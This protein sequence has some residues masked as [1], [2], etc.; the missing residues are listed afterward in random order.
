MTTRKTFLGGIAGTLLLLLSGTVQ[1]TTLLGDSIEILSLFPTVADVNA[2]GT[3][4]VDDT[5]LDRVTF[6]GGSF[7]HA[8]ALQ[9]SF[10]S[11]FATRFA[12]GN[13]FNPD[14][15]NFISFED[16]DFADGSVISG[17][18]LSSTFG[19]IGVE[20][21]IFGDDFVRFDVAGLPTVAGDSIVVDL[22]TSGG[23][24]PVPLPAGL[25]LF[26]LAVGVLGFARRKSKQI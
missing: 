19:G 20:D 6:G 18:S 2:Q 13:Q 9:L 16:L 7:A 8:D 22:T 10:I 25:P 14:G 24:S 1:A 4:T 17:V 11:P 26:A 12:P 21:I 3:V 23:V 5:D 15:G